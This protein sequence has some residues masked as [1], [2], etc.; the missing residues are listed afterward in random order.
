MAG[1]SDRRAQ[2]ALDAYC[3][4]RG[5]PAS[6]FHRASEGRTNAVFLGES[7]GVVVAVA[8]S[9]ISANCVAAR[10]QLARAIS[11]RAPFVRP[12]PDAEQPLATDGGVVSVWEYVPT[13]PA[14][15]LEVIGAAV[16]RFHAVDGSTVETGTSALGLARVMRDTAEWIDDLAHRRLL[17]PA[18]A[19]VLSIVDNRLLSSLGPPDTGA[20]SLV[21]GD[22]H[23][24][25]VLVTNESAVLCDTDEIGLGSPE[26]DVA[27]LLDSDRQHVSQPDL[28]AFASGYGSP[29]PEI[30]ARRM[31]VQRSH[32]TFTLRAAER[33]TSV[34]GRYWVDQWMAGWRRIVKDDGAILTPPREHSRLEQL[35]VVVRGPLERRVLGLPESAG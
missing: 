11:K 33:A 18:D 22:L 25:N 10:I 4:T 9:G 26:Y 32:L 30:G 12:L 34:R 28:D 8:G 1:R 23:W 29:V 5:W 13:V 35:G 6:E 27:Y 2:R 16:A 15:D 24:P 20:K 7:L 3:A 21:H 19:R 17:R 31:L 14:L